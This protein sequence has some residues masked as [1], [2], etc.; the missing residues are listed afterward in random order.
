[1]K[2]KTCIAKTR[3]ISEVNKSWFRKQKKLKQKKKREAKGQANHHWRAS[4]SSSCS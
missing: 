4:E 3:K 2:E 1:M